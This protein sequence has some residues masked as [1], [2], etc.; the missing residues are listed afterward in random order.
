[1]W[2]A[3]YLLHPP[4]SYKEGVKTIWGYIKSN[5]GVYRP[6]HN[7][8]P[9]ND[10]VCELDDLFKQNPYTLVYTKPSPLLKFL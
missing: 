6:G 8:K 4:Y 5:G 9:S 3:V 1:M 10:K 7:N 2:W